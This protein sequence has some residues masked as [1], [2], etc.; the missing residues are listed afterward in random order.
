[1]SRDVYKEC[2]PGVVGD[3]A[4]PG[5]QSPP[6]VSQSTWPSTLLFTAIGFPCPCQLRS[7]PLKSQTTVLSPASSF[8]FSR[9]YFRGGVWSLG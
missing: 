7:S 1:M 2:G 9:R 5:N 6:W 3:A 4:G 8:F